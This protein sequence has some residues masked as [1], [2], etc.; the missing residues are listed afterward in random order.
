MRENADRLD[1]LISLSIYEK[2]QPSLEEGWSFS[3][4]YPR[5]AEMISVFLGGKGL[6]YFTSLLST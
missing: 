4:I 1:W 6:A 3:W 5:E 2:D